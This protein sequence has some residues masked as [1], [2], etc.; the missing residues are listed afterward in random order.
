MLFE[1]GEEKS[2]EGPSNALSG[3]ITQGN[4]TGVI[5]N[6]DKPPVNLLDNYFMAYHIENQEDQNLANGRLVARISKALISSKISPEKNPIEYRV[7]LITLEHIKRY[8]NI[9][10]VEISNSFMENGLGAVIRD[11][12]Y[13]NIT[14]PLRKGA[15]PV[16]FSLRDENVEMDVDPDTRVNLKRARDVAF[17]GGDKMMGLKFQ[18][19]FS[20]FNDMARVAGEYLGAAQQYKEG[21]NISGGMDRLV[22]ENIQKVEEKEEVAAKMLVSLL[23]KP[24]IQVIGK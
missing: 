9:F 19:M 11:Q 2:Y 23:N 12:V 20:E 18:K 3:G 13:D 14:V 16:G 17:A 8:N 6:A 1:N 21:A 22:L 5:P 15:L 7:A 10:G 24:L 4:W